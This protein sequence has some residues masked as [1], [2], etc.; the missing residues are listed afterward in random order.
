VKEQSLTDLHFVAVAEHLR[1]TLE[2][3]GVTTELADEVLDIVGRTRGKV[4][5]RGEAR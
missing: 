5:G 4:L 3:L 2:E 1:A